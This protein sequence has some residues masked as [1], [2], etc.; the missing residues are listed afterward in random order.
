MLSGNA[1]IDAATLAMTIYEKDGIGLLL[2]IRQ[3]EPLAFRRMRRETARISSQ[4]AVVAKPAA[5][6]GIGR[7]NITS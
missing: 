3:W 5:A 1:R 7:S 4:R 6:L 2:A